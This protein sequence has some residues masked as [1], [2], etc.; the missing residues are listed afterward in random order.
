[1]FSQYIPT[2]KP[3]EMPTRATSGS[4]GYDLRY[5][6]DTF[7]Q[8]E[9]ILAGSFIIERGGIRIVPTNLKVQLPKG[10]FGMICPRSGLAAKHG[11]TVLN[12]PGIVDFD[13]EGHI[14]VIL[15]NHGQDPVMIN[16]GDRIAQMVI[17][18]YSHLEPS[19]TFLGF[20]GDGG[21]GSTGIQ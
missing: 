14:R 1:M 4:A 11:I 8:D 3:Q 18:P 19:G 10:T 13:Y 6:D 9:K 7:D 20:R 21:F 2:T 16:H 5:F 17:V 12:S 15:I